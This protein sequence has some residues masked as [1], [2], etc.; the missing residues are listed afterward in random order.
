MLRRMFSVVLAGLLC[1][2]FLPFARAEGPEIAA[3]SAILMDA[4]TGT[5]LY[6]KN[7]REQLA[8]ASVT[9]V[10]TLLLIMEALDSGR[11][12]WE[13]TVITSEAAAAKGG[14]QVYLEV[15]EEMSMDEML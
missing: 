13:D 6:E 14:S 8:P 4:A 9:K 12:S 7:S 5:V 11:I 10:M 3:P 15:G 2:G 1:I